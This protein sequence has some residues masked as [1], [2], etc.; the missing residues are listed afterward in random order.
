MPIAVALACGGC[1]VGPDFSR[2]KGDDTIPLTGTPLVS[3]TR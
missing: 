1:A 2:P 3:P